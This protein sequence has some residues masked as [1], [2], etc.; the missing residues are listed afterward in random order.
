MKAYFC[1]FFLMNANNKIKNVFFIL[2]FYRR[3]WFFWFLC[4]LQS[5]NP[6]A[7]VTADDQAEYSQAYQDH[8]L[9]LQ[10]FNARVSEIKFLCQKKKKKV[11]QSE[12]SLILAFIRLRNRKIKFLLF[13]FWV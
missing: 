7:Y 11:F 3:I 4:I 6:C 2:F 9:L 5:G 13:D 1:L 8:D 12:K 10:V